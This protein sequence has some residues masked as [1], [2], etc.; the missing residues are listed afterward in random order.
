MSRIGSH[1]RVSNLGAGKFDGAW[2]VQN[3]E[4]QNPSNT[5]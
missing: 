1:N 3:S 4:N 5:L 2:L